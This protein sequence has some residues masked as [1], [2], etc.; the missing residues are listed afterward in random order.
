MEVETAHTET[1]GTND[2]GH[3]VFGLWNIGQLEAT[4]DETQGHDAFYLSGHPIGNR[5]EVRDEDEK[6][7]AC[8][9]FKMD[10][11]T[12]S[13]SRNCSSFKARDIHRL[14][15][16]HLPNHVKSGDIT[17]EKLA[18]LKNLKAGDL[19]AKP[20]ERSESRWC[21][22][23]R[24]LFPETS[25]SSIPSPY[26]QA[27][28]SSTF[29]T[30]SNTPSWAQRSPTYLCRCESDDCGQAHKHSK[31]AV[32]PVIQFKH[33]IGD[34]CNSGGEDEIT[35]CPMEACPLS[36]SS[37][38][39]KDTWG[40][41]CWM[42]DTPILCTRVA[43]YEERGNEVITLISKIQ[44]FCGF[45]FRFDLLLHLILSHSRQVSDILD[46]SA[47]VFSLV[48]FIIPA[49]RKQPLVDFCYHTYHNNTES[50]TQ[51]ERFEKV[52]SWIISRWPP[53]CLC[54]AHGIECLELHGKGSPVC[55]GCGQIFEFLTDSMKSR[56]LGVA[57]VVDRRIRDWLSRAKRTEI[58]SWVEGASAGLASVL[59]FLSSAPPALTSKPY[60]DLESAPD[61]AAADLRS[62]FVLANSDL[63]LQD[64]LNLR[65]VST[66]AKVSRGS[67]SL[68]P[69]SKIAG[70]ENKR[71]YEMTADGMHTCKHCGRKLKCR[72]DFWRH[73]SDIHRTMRRAECPKCGKLF[74]RKDN[75][76]RH[77]VY[78]RGP[79]D[80]GVNNEASASTS[81]QDTEK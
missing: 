66:A 10:P 53:V 1:G 48:S 29:S 37:I 27:S 6:R 2:Q 13:D 73:L 5:Y 71:M 31:Q 38:A 40:P 69:T 34:A 44:L 28:K 36:I 33:D 18:L 74:T 65:G 26:Y 60:M 75:L 16:D 45:Q 62:P 67:G 54:K 4:F 52:F 42:P 30:K 17:S 21:A 79:G 72:S 56:P 55:N 25:A 70:I 76:G 81:T 12:F 80:P 7:F 49:P 57:T 11:A 46:S 35:Y 22:V 78:C 58:L 50:E 15:S 59:S 19:M 20:Q 41:L 43:L 77:S 64:F 24:E 61:R 39:D 68:L 14:F 47:Q 8:P 23:Y 51:I 3:D 32:L 9:F 63:P